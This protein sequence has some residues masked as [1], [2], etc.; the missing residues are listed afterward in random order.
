MGVAFGSAYLIGLV[1]KKHSKHFL[2][3]LFLKNVVSI[4]FCFCFLEDVHLPASSLAN[5]DEEKNYNNRDVYGE[6]MLTSSREDGNEDGGDA[7][8]SVRQPNR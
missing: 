1:E 6:A 3:H 8:I 7:E 2:G 4:F 5:D